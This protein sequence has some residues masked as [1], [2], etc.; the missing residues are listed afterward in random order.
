MK[1]LNSQEALGSILCPRVW[2]LNLYIHLGN[3]KSIGP[4]RVRVYILKVSHSSMVYDKGPKE[5]WWWVMVTFLFVYAKMAQ[6]L[7]V[8]A[9][10]Q[11]KSWDGWVELVPVIA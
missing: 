4:P 11:S 1:G 7:E 5:W 6:L 9:T 3:G 8:E 2:V 10:L